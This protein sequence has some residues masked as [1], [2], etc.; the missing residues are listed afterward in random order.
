MKY[1]ILG[2]N[3]GVYIT[4]VNDDG[5]LKFGSENIKDAHK[6]DSVEYAVSAIVDYYEDVYMRTLSPL[7]RLTIVGV[8]VEN[9]PIYREVPL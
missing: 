8:E 3:R 6:F 4:R 5:D 1:A 9:N 7:G 2:T